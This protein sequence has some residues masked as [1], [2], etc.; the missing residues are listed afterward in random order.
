[1]S[2]LFASRLPIGANSNSRNVKQWVRE[3][4]V[5]SDDATVMVIELRCLE[6]GCPP[7]E[8]VI[9][10]LSENGNRHYELHKSIAEVTEEDALQLLAETLADKAWTQAVSTR[11]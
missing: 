4:F 3:L 9:A 7:L 10:I 6:P 11:N 5:L 8:T 2:D 1:M